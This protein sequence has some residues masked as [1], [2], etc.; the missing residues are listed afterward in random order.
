M[1]KS[2][3]FQGFS[4]PKEN[5]Y[6]AQRLVRSLDTLPRRDWRAFRCSA[7]DI[8]EYAPFHSFGNEHKTVKYYLVF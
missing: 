7:K 1:D 5:Y 4:E 6:T 2:A 8:E 3:N